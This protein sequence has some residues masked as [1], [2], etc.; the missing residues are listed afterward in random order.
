V[1]H[2]PKHV[3][4][5]E[6]LP[7]DEGYVIYEGANDR[8]HYLNPIAALIYELCNGDNSAE[9][10]TELVQQSF[11]LVDT[12]APDVTKALEQMKTEGLIQ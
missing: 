3:E 9:Y 8:V 7:A 6:I 5:F 2:Y 12:P 4:G 11:A 1:H 10:I